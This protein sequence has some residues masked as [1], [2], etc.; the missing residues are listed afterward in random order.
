MYVTDKRWRDDLAEDREMHCDDDDMIVIN[1][2]IAK[3][4]GEPSLA[5]PI[6]VLMQVPYSNA[7]CA[8][9]RQKKEEKT[10]EDIFQNDLKVMD[11]RR[12]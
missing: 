5:D 6:I 10:D 9:R 7:L 2:R 1:V 3:E 8:R 12:N 4:P 11:V